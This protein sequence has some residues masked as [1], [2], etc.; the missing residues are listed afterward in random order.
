M[1]SRH[2]SRVERVE[3]EEAPDEEA[4]E[5]E[6][7]WLF[8]GTF[9]GSSTFPIFTFLSPTKI[10][11]PLTRRSP[12]RTTPDTRRGRRGGELDERRGSRPFPRLYSRGTD[13]TPVRIARRS[14]VRSLQ[15]VVQSLD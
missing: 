7:N 13:Y 15:G 4:A 9:R 8:S 1:A 12:R 10:P 14:L 2:E 11:S 6:R 3:R 5:V